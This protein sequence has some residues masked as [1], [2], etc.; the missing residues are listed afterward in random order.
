MEVCIGIPTLNGPDRLHRCLKSIKN[1]TPLEGYK[2]EVLVSDDG[3]TPE[4][5]SLIKSICHEFNTPLLMTDVRLGVA[6]QWNRLTL[7]TQAPVMILMNDDIEVVPDWLEALVFSIRNNQHAG[8]ISL[9]AYQG[10][11]STHFALPPVPSYNE[12]IME[13]G[14]GLLSSHGFLFGFERSKFD[15][16]GGFDPQFLAFYEELDFGVRLLLKNWPSYILSH[17][18]VLHQGGATTTDPINLDAQKTLSESREKFKAKHVSVQNVRDR[19]LGQT[20]PKCLHWNTGLKT[21]TD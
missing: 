1:N 15:E 13:H 4:N 19:T 20:Y 11:N 5:L 14:H 7:H 9:K 6:K 17:P 3:S 2:A 10:V 12:A 8:M 21:L 16:V 18:I